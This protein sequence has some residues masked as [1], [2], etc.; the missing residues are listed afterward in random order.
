M[1]ANLI[2]IPLAAAL[3]LRFRGHD[4]SLALIGSF[5]FLA[6]AV[7]ELVRFT[8]HMALG[9]LALDFVVASGSEADAI[10]AAARAVSLVI[11]YSLALGP[12]G[13]ALGIFSYGALVVRTQ[14]LPRWIGWIGVVGGVVAPFG[15]L[16]FVQQ[17]LFYIGAAGLII[18]LVFAVTAGVRLLAS[19]SAEA[20]SG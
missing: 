20:A 2:S 3:Y 8:A 1:F 11:Y 16:T 12:M 13:I 19:G 18:G 9:S 6:A 7:L 15:W 17:D 10:A 14:A 5:G 4:R